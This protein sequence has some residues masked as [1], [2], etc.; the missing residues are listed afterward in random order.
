MQRWLRFLP[1]LVDAGYEVHVLAPQDGDFPHIDESL[2]KRIPKEVCVHRCSAPKVGSFWQFL[3]GK[4]VKLPHG[5]LSLDAN[6]SFMARILLWLRLNFIFPDLRVFW[7]PRAIPKAKQ[8]L[9]EHGFKLVI[10][11]GPPHSSHLIGLHLKK[12]FKKIQWVADWRDPWS[13]IYYLKLEKPLFYARY[14]QRY[15]QNKVVKTADLNLLIS[16]HLLQQLPDGNK[17]LLRNG[18]DGKSI[19]KA[20][21]AAKAQKDVFIISYVGQVT[22]GQDIELLLKIL[23][24]IS[25]K[26]D[27]KIR[28]IGSKVSAELLKRFVSILK[29]SFELIPFMPHQQALNLMAASDLLI[30]L[31]NRY[32]GHQGM[33][34]TKLFE[35]L[36]MGVPILALGPQGGEA[37]DLI[38]SYQA[39]KLFDQDQAPQAITWL[40]EQYQHFE[41]GTSS[42]QKHDLS[43]LSSSHQSQLLI[44]ALS[45]LN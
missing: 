12:H 8:L 39:G 7:L 32:E 9:R 17:L 27:V 24:P 38:Q 43:S 26:K 11:T 13:D 36:G 20:K 6:S 34:T 10:S 35:Y 22:M 45:K 21:K 28:F 41:R 23:Q 3:F 16:Q 33:L 25:E 40:N 4:A 30:L 44:Q 2:L 37:Q 18:F 15:L 14:M 31:I 5:D 42:T 1:F 29:G 19:D